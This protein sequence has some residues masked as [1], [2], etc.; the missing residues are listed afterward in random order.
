[1]LMIDQTLN[2][3]IRTAIQHLLDHMYQ[4]YKTLDNLTT[5]NYD[6]ILERTG[7]TLNIPKRE[8]KTMI[9]SIPKF[10]GE[11]DEAPWYEVE[12]AL[13][14][15]PQVKSCNQADAISMFLLR[16]SGPARQSISELDLKESA[17]LQTVTSKL[18][19]IFGN[20]VKT[21]R[22]IRTNHIKTGHINHAS[23]AK[24]F[25]SLYCISHR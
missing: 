20:P 13:N 10:S 1:M 21:L 25:E 23:S 6:Y 7:G 12:A 4:I 3:D 5:N 24:R 19:L 15:I 14:K 11:S 2:S 18:K 17:T 8:L 9:G 22:Q 16:L